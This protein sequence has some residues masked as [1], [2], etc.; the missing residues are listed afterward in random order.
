M[1]EVPFLDL[2]A[3]VH[4]E[5]AELDAIW[6]RFLDSG[7]FILGP[8][9]ARFEAAFAAAL[10]VAEAVGTGNGLDALALALEA[11]GI[12]PGDE[13]LVPAHTF[14]A[15]WAAVRLVG[16]RPVPVEPEG[17]VM[18]EP[19][20]WEAARGARTRALV[21][22]HLYGEVTDMTGILAA[23]GGLP[24]IED[25]AQAHGARRFGRAAGSFGTAAAFSFYPAKTLGALGDGGAVVTSDPG[26]ATRVRRLG[27]YGGTAKHEHEV[28]GRNSRLD[29]LQAMV[30]SMRLERL[31]AAVV[32]RAAVAAHYDSALGGI[33]GLRLPVP[34]GEPGWHLYVVRTPARDRLAAHLA[35]AGVASQVHYPRPVYRLPPF[36][37]GAPPQGS[38]ADRL[39][40]EI[41][42]LPIG[43]HQT[44]PQ[45]EAVVTAV[46]G[47]FGR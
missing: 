28:A 13:V 20:A 15:T 44:E 35:A 3:A 39:C 45:T 32:A 12:G 10:G 5:R 14:V 30:L 31:G 47:F 29:P 37:E 36:A 46:R 4:A 34:E 11:A 38:P 2:A 1:T 42:S 6:A 23:A 8:E 9:V 19:A 40:A 22:V 43:P 16:A 25:A 26:L 27:N 7:R 17:G 18:P 21:P 24:V 33:D 41:L